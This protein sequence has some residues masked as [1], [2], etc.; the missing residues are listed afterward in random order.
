MKIVRILDNMVDFIC[1]IIF[2]MI[3]LIGFYYIYDTYYIFYNA[4]AG[5]TMANK[6]GSTLVA[7]KQLT[8]DYIA[9]LTIDDT[10]IDYPI[11]QGKTNNDYLNKNPYGEYSLSGSIFLD[12]RND[13]NFNDSYSLVYGHH[14]EKDYMF[15]ALD[16]FVDELYF[17]KHQTGKLILKDGKEYKIDLFAVV[18][19]D[20]SV[21]VI[22]DPSGSD[23]VL[24][25]L[26]HNT[27]LKEPNNKHIVAF[28]TCL[29]PGSTERTV[30]FGTL[31]K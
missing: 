14:M 20:V 31:E 30:L 8:N 2:I 22:F 4:S 27:F 6:P 13:P 25:Y 1:R 17:K 19:V 28:S 12:S 9:W 23:V 29:E 26:D 7:D 15:G 16:A 18:K 24:N 3:M 11:M 10:T 21:N 5:R